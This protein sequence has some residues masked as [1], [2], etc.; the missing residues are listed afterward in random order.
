M[1]PGELLLGEGSIPLNEGAPRTTLRITNT[2]DRPIQ[3]GSHYHFAQVNDAL[4]FERSAAQGLRLDVP[5][6]TAVR[7]EPGIERDVDLVPLGGAR[8]VPGLR[9]S[10]PT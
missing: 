9:W 5:A 7:F 2:G 6:G 8:L 3:V 1:I 10:R 4:H